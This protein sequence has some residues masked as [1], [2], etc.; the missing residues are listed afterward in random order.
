[1]LRSANRLD[2]QGAWEVKRRIKIPALRDT[3]D[4]QA[5]QGLLKRLPG[6]R[7]TVADS[8]NNQVLVVYDITRQDYRGILAALAQEGYPIA[9]TRW[10]RFKTRWLQSM[11]E[12]GRDNAH[13]PAPVC[14]SNPK[15]IVQAKKH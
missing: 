13:A 10:N 1:M 11:D 6:V 3:G 7:G 8:A 14:C 2:V 15:G 12:T 5:V 9:D 4:A